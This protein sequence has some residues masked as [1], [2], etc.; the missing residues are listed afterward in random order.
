MKAQEKPDMNRTRD[1]CRAQPVDSKWKLRLLAGPAGISGH[2]WANIHANTVKKIS[3]INTL[4][5]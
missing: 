5:G 4:S 1:A 2:G 3:D